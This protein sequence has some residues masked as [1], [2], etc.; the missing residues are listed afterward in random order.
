V[1][2]WCVAILI[3]R[4]R[5]QIIS[6]RGMGVRADIGRLHDV[7]RVRIGELTMISPEVARLALVSASAAEQE[8]EPKRVGEGLFLISMSETDP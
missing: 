7:P 6:V 2:L 5:A 3:W 8:G 4:R 1:V